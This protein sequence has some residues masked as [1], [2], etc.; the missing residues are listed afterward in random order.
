MYFDFVH[1]TKRTDHG[2]FNLAARNVAYLQVAGL[3]CKDKKRA[4]GENGN[5]GYIKK[6]PVGSEANRLGREYEIGIYE[7][8]NDIFFFVNT[9]CRLF[10]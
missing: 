4:A 3:K 1:G 7:Q 10:F 2:A 8:Y 5:R 9:L 6:N